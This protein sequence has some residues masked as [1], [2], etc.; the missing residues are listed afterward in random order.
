[1][2]LLNYLCKAIMSQLKDYCKK[3]QD[4]IFGYMEKCFNEFGCEMSLHAL[5]T[6]LI[7]LLISG[8][9]MLGFLRF[10]HF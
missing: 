9:L 10:L 3:I 2:L 5:F 8:L 7:T 4:G 6:I 1:M